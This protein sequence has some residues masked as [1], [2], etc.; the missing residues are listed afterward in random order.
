MRG[1]REGIDGVWIE[2]RYRE[3]RRECIGGVVRGRERDREVKGRGMSVERDN[4]LL[5]G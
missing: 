3:L 2:R 1:E 4:G 5:G